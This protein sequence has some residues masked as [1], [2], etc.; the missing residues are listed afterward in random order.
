VGAVLRNSLLRRP[1]LV[2]GCRKRS[3][4]PLCPITGTGSSRSLCKVNIGLPISS[5]VINLATWLVC[6]KECMCSEEYDGITVE[7][8][9]LLVFPGLQKYLQ[10]IKP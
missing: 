9:R 2:Q 10:T 7:T 6:L 5:A 4:L 3:L 8:T 1:G